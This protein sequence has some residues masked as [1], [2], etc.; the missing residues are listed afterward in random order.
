[1][2]AYH[3]GPIWPE[4]AALTVWRNRHA[5]MSFAT[6]EQLPTAAAIAE[7]FALDNGAYSNW[8]A[9]KPADWEGYYA[10]IEQWHRH[11]GFDFAVIPD[12][13][14]GN[15]AENDSLVF[16]QWPFNRSIG[17][18]VWHLHESLNRLEVLLGEF[19]RVALGSSGEWANPGTQRWWARMAAAMETACNSQGRPKAKLHGLR[20]LNPTIVRHLPL[21]SADSTTVAHGI[22]IDK[23]W[24][25]SYQ[26]TNK[27]TRALVV[28]NMLE[29]IRPA[30]EWKAMHIQDQLLEMYAE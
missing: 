24:T 13:V 21:A 3:G 12:V 19:P 6:P 15:E 28:A 16:T 17:V 11:P 9:G 26:P 4:R 5:M 29:P 8:K 7:S 27:E 14:D 2:I 23:R 25:G 10:W 18:P 20:M 30:T 22:I 1:M